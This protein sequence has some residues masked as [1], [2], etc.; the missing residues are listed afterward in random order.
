MA[1]NGYD[2]PACQINEDL[3]DRISS[4]P[5]QPSLD[6]ASTDR[7]ND[8]SV[9]RLTSLNL[10]ASIGGP[11]LGQRDLSIVRSSS[12]KRKPG[13]T[14]QESRKV[15]TIPPTYPWLKEKR[16]RPQ[17][18][19]VPG[20]FGS[21]LEPHAEQ[22]SD[23]TSSARNELTATTPINVESARPQEAPHVSSSTA[24]ESLHH[25]K[26][27]GTVSVR[28]K[29]SLR[30][31]GSQDSLKSIASSRALMKPHA[32]SSLSRQIAEPVMMREI[33]QMPSNYVVCFSIKEPSS[34]HSRLQKLTSKRILAL[35]PSALIHLI[36]PNFTSMFKEGQRKTVVRSNLL[37][38]RRSMEPPYPNFCLSYRQSSNVQ[39]MTSMLLKARRKD[40]TMLHNWIYDLS[41]SESTAESY[42]PSRLFHNVLSPFKA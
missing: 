39:L 31:K 9:Q 20:S 37:F 38:S 17:V 24:L 34:F 25:V 15:P 22:N 16:L 32:E 6:S 40:S 13:P 26:D 21:I 4:Q 7:G 35:C 3:A 11:S 41:L 29:A 1:T 12:F 23:L 5:S 18:Q 42:H 8:N 2:G 27:S 36:N 33:E 30:G 19:H 14:T 28:S 10:R